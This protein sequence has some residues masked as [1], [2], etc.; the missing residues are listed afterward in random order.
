MAHQTPH[1]D[2]LGHR[3]IISN[4]NVYTLAQECK[5]GWRTFPKGEQFVRVDWGSETEKTQ[6]YVNR[7]G[8]PLLT[9]QN[10]FEIKAV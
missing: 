1:R 6:R 3:Y 7:D 4:S 2:N 9:N 8:Y 10:A 5:N